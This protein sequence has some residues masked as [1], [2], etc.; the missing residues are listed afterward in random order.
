MYRVTALFIFAFTYFSTTAQVTGIANFADSLATKKK[1]SGTILIAKAGKQLYQK[2]FGFADIPFNVPNDST[3][4]YKIASLTKIF[5]ATLILQLAEQGNIDLDQTFG[6]YL[7]GYKGPA[8]TRVTVRQLLNMTSGMRNMDDGIT[9]EAAIKGEIQQYQKPHSSDEMLALYCSD[10]LVN[11]PGKKFDYN[12][13]EYIILGK[14]IEAVSGNSLD[15]HLYATLFKP[16]GIQHSGLSDHIR[17]VP[18]LAHNYTWQ[19]E[20]RQL[21]NDIP[22]FI[23]N[24]YAAGSMYATAGDILRFSR[25]LFGGKLL[26]RSS[27]EKMIDP[28]TAE[29]GFGVYVYKDYNINGHLYTLIKRPGQISSAQTLLFHLVELNATIIILANT[30]QASPDELAAALAERWLSGKVKK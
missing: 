4:R 16:L 11:E 21:V 6:K 1:F 29:Y 20:S 26:Q 7:P 10:T 5:T 24:W 28:G 2:S 3:T 27:I 8:G 25:A 14:I 13:A 19:E 17:I 23:Q 22:L 30:N 12:N 15:K 18:R 9:M